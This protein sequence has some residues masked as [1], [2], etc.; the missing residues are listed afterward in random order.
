MRF[1]LLCLLTSAY[2]TRKQQQNAISESGI[3]MFDDEE[4]FPRSSGIFAA[5]YEFEKREKWF[6]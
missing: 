3:Q 2:F 6:N 4:K 1:L 5:L